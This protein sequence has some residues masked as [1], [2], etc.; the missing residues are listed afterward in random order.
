MVG[1][2]ASRPLRLG[3]LSPTP[4]KYFSPELAR[5]DRHAY[6]ALR[7]VIRKFQN[8]ESVQCQLGRIKVIPTLTT[9]IREA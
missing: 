5:D 3:G 2:Y 6:N 1:S 7:G 4:I 9:E 8:E